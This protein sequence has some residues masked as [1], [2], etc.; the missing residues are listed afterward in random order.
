MRIMFH[1]A[2]VT[3]QKGD[4]SY[5]YWLENAFQEVDGVRLSRKGYGGCHFN[6]AAFVNIASDTSDA[7]DICVLDWNTTGLPEFDQSK[8][9]Y[10][11][12]VLL[13][14]GILPV[15]VIFASEQNT[16]ETERAAERQVIDFCRTNALPLWDY[17]DRIVRETH[18]RDTVHTNIA[19][20]KIYADCIFVDLTKLMREIKKYSMKMPAEAHNFKIIEAPE[21]FL[22][23]PEGSSLKFELKS[24]SDG[25]HI[26][27]K[28]IHGPSSPI[29]ELENGQKLSVW[30]RWSHYE[31]SGF[32]TLWSAEPLERDRCTI[33]IKVLR[34]QIDYSICARPFSFE[35]EKVFKLTGLYF[36]NCAMD[37]VSVQSI[38]RIRDRLSAYKMLMKNTLSVRAQAFGRS[39]LK[40]LD[41]RFF[42]RAR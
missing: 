7:P 23:V 28:V 16:A 38:G 24:V 2:S 33:K 37:S 40:A 19:G 10:V 20:A 26:L 8:L 41:R 15:F 4:G 5:F 35:G 29:I 11:S 14:R 27:A 12:G 39:R 18:L 1:G 6:D 21:F 36:V 34:D 17:R 31:R 25:A 9:S 30:D 22:D 32:L 13:E 3:E 42:G